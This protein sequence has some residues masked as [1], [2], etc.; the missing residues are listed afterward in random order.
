M[1]RL[2]MVCVLVMFLFAFSSAVIADGEYLSGENVLERLEEYI[3]EE[4]ARSL[5]D[6][7]LEG[8]AKDEVSSLFSFS[9]F[10]GLLK[11]VFSSAI[12]YCLSSV[13]PLFA[14]VI[15]SSL[16]HM[17]SRTVENSATNEVFSCVSSLCL[18]VYIFNIVNG[19]FTKTSSYLSALASFASVITPLCSIVYASGGNVGAAAVS[20]SGL[21]VCVTLVQAVTAYVLTPVLG[22]YAVLTAASSLSPKLRIGTLSNFVRG[23]L[24]LLIS[25][26]AAA[27][28]AIVAFQHTLATAAD[29]IGTRAIRF[30][31]SSFIPIVGSAVSEAVRTVSV[32]ISYIR[33][34]VG[35]VGILAI[36][37]LVLPTF[38]ELMSA[39]ILFAL[40]AS[41][42]DILGCA[43]ECNVIK[44]AGA[45]VNFL[46]A[47]VS[48]TSV[49]IIY[50]FTLLAHCAASYG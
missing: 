2:M 13:T 30:A 9:Y 12:E 14:I 6:G 18:C 31:A 45:I 4:V 20:T 27:I 17:L 48:I 26:S 35:G 15:L 23:F 5:P 42:A 11:S 19:M 33:T 8:R 39:R 49:L 28:S 29:S 50:F 44:G 41:L 32:G 10:G 43:R 24:T 7:L 22:A 16:F 37:I 34:V 36:V 38:A 25:L 21:L 46:I 1:K 47:L 40:G 3:P